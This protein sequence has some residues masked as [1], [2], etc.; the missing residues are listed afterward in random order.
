MDQEALHVA[1]ADE[2]QSRPLSR[3]IEATQANERTVST[4]LPITN[5]VPSLALRRST[6]RSTRL[7]VTSLH[8]YE[9][10]LFQFAMSWLF[11]FWLVRFLSHLSRSMLHL[12]TNL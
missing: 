1:A 2:P 6:V 3:Q 11:Q 10:F 5:I 4:Q 8:A 7:K 9:S 12:L